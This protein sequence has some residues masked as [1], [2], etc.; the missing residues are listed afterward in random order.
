M[1]T[2][3]VRV[4]TH[5]CGFL[6]WLYSLSMLPPMV[7]A[8]FYKE[9]S[10]FVFFITFVIF[11][12][13]G[14]GA[15][16]TTKKSGIQLRTR[17][18]FII[19]VMFWILFSVI[20]AFPLWIDSEL[21]LTFIDA[22][23]EGVSGITTT[24]ATVIDDVSSL[25]RAYLYYRSQ[26]NFIGG[27]GVIVLAVAV[28][29]LLGIGGAKLYQSEM[30][31]PFKDD[32][33]TPRLADTSRTLWI[34]YSLLG[35]ACIVCY[36][37]AGMPLFDA[38]CHGI[39]TVSLGG[40]STHSESIGYFNNYLVELVAGSFSLL[41][42]F[43][44]TLWYIVISRKTIK[45]LI[46]DI[47]LRFFLLMALGVIIVT[48]FQV[49]HIGMYDLHGS[50]IHSFFLASSMLTDN[51]LATQDYASW[52][53]HTIVFLL[54]SSFFGGCIGSTCGGIKSLRFLILFKQSKHEINQLSHPRALLSVNVGGK[55]VTDR[56]MRSVWSFFF[57]YTLF[58]VFFILVLNGMGYDFLT[59]FATVA[60][61]IN[62]MGLGFGATASSF[63]VL[64]DIAK[65][66]MCIAM[67]LGR[68]EIYPVIILFSGFFWRS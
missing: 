41:S 58:T 37:L 34:T 54:L 60:A 47:E 43:N 45:P 19:I 36:R 22:L 26:L 44:F 24:G 38:I 15:W 25:P 62:N 48:S 33:L 27:L 17:D 66:L 7:V 18:G 9:K 57:L 68:L 23:F 39:S 51:G 4:V 59:S 16:Y 56:V 28:L 63:G 11:F 55:I 31:G 64:N 20:S 10:L 46:R 42:A 12:C 1:N 65:C 5:M 21:N 61:C 32:K 50:F 52:P 6:V 8:L 53:T 30:P 40:F 49:W 67:I 2:S 3:H 29:P 14:G 13:I 35:I